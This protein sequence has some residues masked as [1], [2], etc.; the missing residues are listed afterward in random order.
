MR[1]SRA[2]QIDPGSGDLHR[3]AA[4]AARRR[5]NQLTA[6]N[7]QS[8]LGGLNHIQQLGWRLLEAARC[9]GSLKQ[10]LDR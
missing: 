5:Q 7:G 6:K 8:E 2:I 1:V 3:L 9:R 10:A 4:A